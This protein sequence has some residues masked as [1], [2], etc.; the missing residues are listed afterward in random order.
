MYKKIRNCVNLKNAFNLGMLKVQLRQVES[1]VQTGHLMREFADEESKIYKALKKNLR[2]IARILFRALKPVIRPVAFRARRYF[3]DALDSQISLL[4]DHIQALEKSLAELRSMVLQQSRPAMTT[5]AEVL[6]RSNMGY[7]LCD[8]NDDKVLACL[9]NG[10]ELES[11]T[12]LL[13]EKLLKPYSIFIDVGAHIGLHTIAAASAMQGKGSIFAFEPCV[14]NKQLLEKNIRINGYAD[15]VRIYPQAAFNK[16]GNHTL[17]LGRVSG[18]HSLFNMPDAVSSTQV[19]T[20]TI[21]SV[22]DSA[23]AVDLIKIDVEGAELQALEGA[24]A[25]IQRNKEIALIVEYGPSHLQRVGI[26]RQD[27]FASFEKLGLIWRVINPLN[28]AIEDWPIAKLEEIESVNLLFAFPG[29]SV[30][31]QVEA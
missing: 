20:V 12:R 22:V 26:L 21:D 24:R 19:S 15:V 13:I 7:V 4:T 23:L 16:N 8:A 2:P 17:F 14:L 29:A 30:W 6:V 27:W 25:T 5:G 11:G 18:H 28:G 3:N 1:V 10:G 31:R 9:L